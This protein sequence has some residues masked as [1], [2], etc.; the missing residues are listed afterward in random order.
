MLSNLRRK[1][2]QTGSGYL[3][4]EIIRKHLFFMYRYMNLDCSWRCYPD[5]SEL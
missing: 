5:F 4:K 2:S 3:Q 1:E